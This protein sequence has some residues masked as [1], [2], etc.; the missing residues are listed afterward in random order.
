M[1]DHNSFVLQVMTA[2]GWNQ[3]N[4]LYNAL[5]CELSWDLE[6]CLN[7]I[8]ESDWAG[9]GLGSSELQNQITIAQREVLEFLKQVHHSMSEEHT[10]QSRVR[11]PFV[12]IENPDFKESHRIYLDLK[13]YLQKKWS[14]Y[15]HEWRQS[16]SMFQLERF[17][18][19]CLQNRANEKQIRFQSQEVLL[20]ELAN[21]VINALG[22]SED[23]RKAIHLK[24]RLVVS[25]EYCVTLDRVPKDLLPV[26]LQNTRQLESWCNLYQLKT[27]ADGIDISFLCAHPFM[28]LD[29][30]FFDSD[31]KH[32][33]LA[34]FQDIDSA[35]DGLI[36]R[37]ENAAALRLIHSRFS[38]EV[39]T[40][41]ID[42]P[43]NTGLD[44]FAYRDSYPHQNWQSMM[45]ER[46][47]LADAFLKQ[48]GVLFASINDNESRELETLLKSIWGPE[49]YQARLSI[50]VRHEDR[51]L[52]KDIP[53]QE[54]LEDVHMVS[55]NK[56]FVPGRR[57]PKKDPMAQYVYE[58]QMLSD[59][60]QAVL[61]IEPYAKI[62]VYYQSDY[63]LIKHQ[64]GS[65]NHFKSYNIRGSLITQKGSA[66]AFYEA[67]LRQRRSIDG[68]G[69][70]YKIIG[71]GMRGDGLGYRYVRQPFRASAQNGFYYQGYVERD[72]SLPMP[73][74]YDLSEPWSRCSK[75]GG[76]PFRGGKKPQK[77]FQILEQIGQVNSQ[78]TLLDFFA[79][80]GSAGQS[81]IEFNRR[82]HSQRKYIL[83]ECAEYFESVLKTR[84]KKVVF[85]SDWTKKEVS[86][87][88]GISQMIKVLMLEPV[89]AAVSQVEQCVLPHRQGADP[90][91]MV[92]L[93]PVGIPSAIKNP[94]SFE[95][96]DYEDN[97]KVCHRIDWIESFS[98]LLGLRVTRFGPKTRIEWPSHN[99]SC[100]FLPII[101][102]RPKDENDRQTFLILWRNWS[103]DREKDDEMLEEW[104][105]QSKIDW[106]YIDSL[107][108]NGPTHLSFPVE[109]V[110]VI[111]T[112]L[113]QLVWNQG[114]A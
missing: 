51:I 44:T 49:C 71:M 110:N 83:I 13:A 70:L 88:T 8:W 46:L 25:T 40:I 19:L 109:T 39:D 84:L 37:G 56:K 65:K 11:L 94:W 103:D 102:W 93:M 16:Q 9:L 105:N 38:D 78:G 74:Y 3:K 89:D 106:T 69:A 81:V 61:Q 79:G 101:G 86:K 7:T 10:L 64:K 95:P 114:D 35:C 112:H 32:L 17:T 97:S 76:V 5:K 41:Y 18:D 75:E 52:R 72:H 111:E 27:P 90:L 100:T 54:V 42:P 22:K 67:H 20:S 36:I 73:N 104:L 43:Y 82:N 33:L 29:T 24:Q 21:I 57:Q 68:E 85:A 6:R 26:V 53:I 23:L 66:S 91:S 60:P 50:K 1:A 12:F 2:T 92:H 58:I 15:L 63:K 99:D 98:L 30:Q 113:S 59:S 47:K 87:N 80:S 31:F 45:M 96:Q 28:M 62:E 34:S 4:T 55:K 107:Y 77:L 14:I 48:T 108:I